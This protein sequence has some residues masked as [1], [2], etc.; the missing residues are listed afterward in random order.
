[1]SGGPPITGYPDMRGGGYPISHHPGGY[2]VSVNP[3]G[4]SREDLD[5]SRTSQTSYG[6][7]E[8]R[9]SGTVHL[10]GSEYPIGGTVGSSGLF[11]IGNINTFVQRKRKFCC[12]TNNFVIKLFFT[13]LF[14]RHCKRKLC[15]RLRINLKKY[16]MHLLR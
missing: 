11:V 13:L 5:T 4:A 2:P 9:S 10:G 3:A 14:E 16:I 1:M 7:R 15:Y 8:S 6:S 12:E